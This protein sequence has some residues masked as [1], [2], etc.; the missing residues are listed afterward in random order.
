MQK[1]EKRRGGA[2][3]TEPWRDKESGGVENAIIT[4]TDH[5]SRAPDVKNILS[6]FAHSV[7][8][9][10]FRTE[11]CPLFADFTQ[12]EAE[13][14]RGQVTSVQIIP[15]G[16]SFMP[17]GSPNPRD[18]A[19]CTVFPRLCQINLDLFKPLHSNL[20]YVPFTFPSHTN[21]TTRKRQ[22]HGQQQTKNTA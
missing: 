11:A 21:S 1:R 7:S 3:A 5:G 2:F 6:N 17:P 12:E 20:T 14:W 4:D 10:S 18:S 15:M 16:V 8:H 13:A 19:T 9:L 22:R